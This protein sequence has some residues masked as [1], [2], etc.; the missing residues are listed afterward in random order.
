MPGA[1]LLTSVCPIVEAI[2]DADVSRVMEF[3]WPLIVMFGWGAGLIGHAVDTFIN[4]AH[5]GKR[6]E[7]IQREIER[8]RERLR[9]DGYTL[10]DKPKNDFN[11]RL[12]E[13]GELTD[14]IAQEWNMDEERRRSRR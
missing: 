8:E 1:V 10:V 2:G 6:E 5:N 9:M 13:D 12:T 11:M 3:P 7:A 4:P 14:S